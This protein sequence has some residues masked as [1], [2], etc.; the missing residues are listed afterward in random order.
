MKRILAL[1]LCFALLFSLVAC[2][3]RAVPSSSDVKAAVQEEYDMKFKLDS[4]KIA[5]RAFRIRL[6]YWLFWAAMAAGY[7]LRLARLVAARRAAARG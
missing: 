6:F 1:V 4:E 2:N 3:R 5:A 7:L